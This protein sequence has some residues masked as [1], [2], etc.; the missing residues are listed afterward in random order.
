MTTMATSIECDTG[1]GEPHEADPTVREN[2]KEA[3]NALKWHVV[4][5]FS[6]MCFKFSNLT[7]DSTTE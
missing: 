1:S 6:P 2:A 3:R 4:G 7:G 5:M